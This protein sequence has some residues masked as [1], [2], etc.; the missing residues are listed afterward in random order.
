MNAVLS[1]SGASI[2]ILACLLI[3]SAYAQDNSG[4]GKNAGF[5]HPLE[6]SSRQVLDNTAPFGNQKANSESANDLVYAGSAQ[7][8]A[9][10]DIELHGDLLYCA[11]VNGLMIYDV[12]DP[13]IP[14]LLAQ[15]YLDRNVTNVEISDNLLYLGFANGDIA[16]YGLSDPM[17]PNKLGEHNSDFGGVTALTIW[18]N[19]AFVGQNTYGMEIVDIT[20]S[21]NPF[22]LGL[23]PTQGHAPHGY[24]VIGDTVYV[25]AGR[26]WAFD[27]ST[28]SMP[29]SIACIEVPEYGW[30]VQ[31]VDT[32]AYVAG[33]SDVQPYMYSE[34]SI[35]N[36]SDLTK[37][38]LLSSFRMSCN[39]YGVEIVDSLA[40]VAAGESGVAIFD[41]GNPGE[42]MVVGCFGGT[43]MTN[44]ILVIDSIV[45]ASSYR[46]S[47]VESMPMGYRDIC[48]DTFIPE[49]KYFGDLIV[50][51]VSNP[52]EPTEISRI[53]NPDLATS[54]SLYS[55]LAVVCSEM[56]GG[57]TI[58]RF[59]NAGHLELIS[60]TQVA[61]YPQAAI[62]RGN[63]IYVASI[64]GGLGIVE[65]SDIA[66]PFQI[67]QYDTIGMAIDVALS[68]NYAVI[69]DGFGFS[70]ID[71]SNPEMPQLV[72]R[73][74]TSGF[75]LEVE[76]S[77]NY[78]F[79]SDREGGL[80]I[81]G[82]ADIYNP[83]LKT[84]YPEVGDGWSRTYLAVHGDILC[85]SKANAVVE[86][87]DISNPVEPEFI[88]EFHCM[89]TMYGL[90]MNKDIAIIA[91]SWY[92]IDVV[93]ITDIQN[94]V[95]AAEH[96]T[97]FIA[98]DVAV[99]SD[100]IFVADCFSLLCFFP[101]NVSDIDNHE[102]NIP[103]LPSGIE[104]Y[105]NFPNPFNPS[106]QIRF[107]IPR[108]T[109]V[110][111]EIFNVLGQRVTTL[112][113]KRLPA[114]E[115]TV[116]WD[117]CDADGKRVASG[118]YLY[119]LTAGEYSTSKQMVLSK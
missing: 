119:R 17:S 27:V 22:C 92:G 76:I 75:S 30:D 33:R 89:Y 32:L 108:V 38:Q 115:H 110:T 85:L 118:I 87:L 113:D 70:I 98:Y 65:A 18:N 90:S 67:G 13:E 28:P 62:M 51:D 77:G 73:Y 12:S 68:G 21:E 100:Y 19:L 56:F 5:A 6:M 97:P 64:W 96:D 23:H 20:Q 66:N 78:L 10:I 4:Q 41:I 3:A 9:R 14:S 107:S 94:P 63:Y 81:F 35:F 112:V 101:P 15:I 40:Y 74:G 116:E 1:K 42:I 102:G 55:D 57:V 114:G 61:G 52:V 80:K 104:L 8:S 48:A 53:V 79:L 25:A 99:N 29:D 88:S 37:P 7:W 16:I 47:F 2:L 44:Q 11:M 58:S 109:D 82:I 69:T 83:V 106:T 36:I 43:G 50:L 72:N 86:F 59:D 45:Y 39:I 93:D 103:G 95:S 31:V 54:V 111:L 24:D 34:L 84:T 105:P 60:R 26:L 46:P 117:G 71:V 49:I 91:Y